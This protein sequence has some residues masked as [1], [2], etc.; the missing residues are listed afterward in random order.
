MC[1]EK[2]PKRDFFF[3]YCGRGLNFGRSASSDVDSL[4]QM[5]ALKTVFKKMTGLPMNPVS[6]WFELEVASPPPTFFP[7]CL[8]QSWLNVTV[9]RGFIYRKTNFVF[10][11][12]GS[13]L[14][15]DVIIKTI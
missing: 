3:R 7:S 4:D 10:K 8:N 12:G 13:H 15:C 14:G 9:R 2:E 1:A 6:H 5:I 11:H